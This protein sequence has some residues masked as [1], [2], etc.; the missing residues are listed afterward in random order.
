[1]I[2]TK[3]NGDPYSK[4]RYSQVLGN[5][6][7]AGLLASEATY[8]CLLLPN[9]VAAM[10]FDAKG[11]AREKCAAHHHN[12]PWDGD[13][14]DWLFP[15]SNKKQAEEWEKECDN[16]VRSGSPFPSA[17]WA[18]GIRLRGAARF[19]ETEPSAA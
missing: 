8:R 19:N 15:P 5:L 18:R 3:P 14:G 1:M 11:R 13:Y 7:A 16:I 10:D 2:L 4:G 6:K 17:D 12:I 9:T